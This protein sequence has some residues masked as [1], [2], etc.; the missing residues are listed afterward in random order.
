[1]E[2]VSVTMREIHHRSLSLLTDFYQLTMAHAYWKSGKKDL[3]AAFHLFFRENPFQGGYTVAAG[4]EQVIEYIT[5]LKYSDEDLDYLGSINGHD[6]CPIFHKEFLNYLRTL[7]FCCDIYGV[8]EGTIVFPHEPLLRVEG[9]IIQA[10][11]LETILLNL[12]NFPTLVATKAARVVHAAGG[13]PVLEFGLRRSQGIDG[14]LSASRAAYLGGCA[15]TSNV[16]AGKR[17]SIPIRGTHAHSWVM[18]FDNELEAFRSYAETMPNNVVFLV[19][20]YSVVEGVKKAIKVGHELK[21]SGESLIGIRLDSG[22]LAELSVKARKMLDEAGLEDVKIFA[23]NDLDESLIQSLKSQG[24]AIE[25][26]GVGTRLVTAYDQPALGGVYKL[27]AIHSSERIW[28]PKIKISEQSAK[29]SNPGVQQV[30][31]FFDGGVAIADMI[32]DCSSPLDEINVLID[33]LDMTMQKKIANHLDHE[34][35]LI[36]IFKAGRQVYEV[37]SLK[38]VR[39]KLRRCLAQFSAGVKRFTNPHLYPVGLEKS[40]FEMKTKLVLQ[41]RSDHF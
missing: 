12:I 7:D 39:D 37:P 32:Y 35:L 30:R 14:G 29:I 36:P 5:E 33:P 13:D 28:T 15:A 1:M 4:L 31:R 27:S 17:Y 23:S 26:W 11:L 8:E 16:L 10:Q 18:A 40:L 9:P 6:G 20:T 21:E 24:A 34:D 25:V 41:S 3:R 19:D 2:I 38:A 22:D